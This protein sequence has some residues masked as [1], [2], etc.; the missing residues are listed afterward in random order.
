VNRNSLRALVARLNPECDTVTDFQG[1]E[2]STRHG[3]GLKITLATVFGDYE[4]C[5]LFREKAYYRPDEPCLVSTGL[6]MM[7]W[8][9]LLDLLLGG[10]ECITYADKD[11]FMCML[12]VGHMR[13]SDIL[14]TRRGQVNPYCGNAA[15]TFAPARTLDQNG[16]RGQVWKDVFELSDFLIDPVSQVLGR[17]DIAKGYLWFDLHRLIQT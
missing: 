13:Y 2:W 12:V 3:A 16:T 1:V 4:P 15:R 17:V 7:I 10:L 5:V 6:S 8:L 9:E 14:S 11:I